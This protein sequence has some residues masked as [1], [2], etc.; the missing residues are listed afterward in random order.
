MAE[1]FF[2]MLG[3]KKYEAISAGTSPTSI[4][5]PLAV[6]VM[7][8]VGVDISGQKPKILTEDMIR[9]STLRIN[10][11][12]MDKGSCPTLFLHNVIDWD[13]EDPKGKP[14]EEVREIRDLIKSKV[15]EFVSSLIQD[16]KQV[17]I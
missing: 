6:E 14:I 4:I 3:P 16:N 15:R 1:G 13:I 9:Q 5:N 8:E 10:M 11:S 17:N 12:C 7:R 2:K